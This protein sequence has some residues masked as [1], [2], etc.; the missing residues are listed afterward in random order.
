MTPLRPRTSRA[1]QDKYLLCLYVSRSTSKSKL[2]IDNIRRM[3][4]EHLKG[5]YDLKV[6]D[7]HGH[8]QL[9]RDQQI[10]A[11]PTLIKRLPAPLQRLV[12]DMSDPDKVLSGLDL[13]LR[14][15]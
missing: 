6:I 3:C 12:G 1:R 8:A 11:V 14:A 4:E 2:A 9:A 7:I 10:V 5:R 15:S 13:Q